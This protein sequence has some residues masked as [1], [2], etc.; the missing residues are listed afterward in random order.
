MERIV[1][2]TIYFHY[3]F[4]IAIVLICLSTRLL[5]SCFKTSVRPP[6]TVLIERDHPKMDY[7]STFSDLTLMVVI[8][9]SVS[10]PA[11]TAF[12]LSLMVLVRYRSSILYLVLEPLY[13]PT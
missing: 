13:L 4:T 8:S 10:T 3:I 7:C 2:D 9:G 12:H 11:K 1:L 5:G 6:T